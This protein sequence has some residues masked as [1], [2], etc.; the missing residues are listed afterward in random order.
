MTPLA[1]ASSKGKV[2]VGRFLIEQGADMNFGDNQS[3]VPSHLASQHEHLDMARLLLDHGVDPNIKR[4]DLSS[5]L[6]LASANSHLKVA[7]LLIQRGASVDVSDDKQETPLYRTVTNGNA[8]IARLLIDHGATVDPVSASCRSFTD[9]T[10]SISQANRL[11]WREWRS[12]SCEVYFRV[13]SECKYLNK[14]R[15]TTLDAVEYGADD[16]GL[17]EANFS[18]H[19]AAEEENIDIVNSLLEWGVD[20]NARNAS[21][22]TPLCKAAAKG[23]VDVVLLLIGGALR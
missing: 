12:S 2:Q 21:S 16:D 1:L 9:E 13:Q 8:A 10:Y 18:L 20:I 3:L 19:A 5:A 17:D 22:R 7:E 4:N 14:L 11:A 15:S 23:K 6:H